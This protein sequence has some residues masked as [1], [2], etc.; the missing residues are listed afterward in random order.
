[1]PIKLPRP[2]VPEPKGP[3]DLEAVHEFVVV[4]K[5]DVWNGLVEKTAQGLPPI[6]NVEDQELAGR[7]CTL[8][9]CNVLLVAVETLLTNDWRRVS[10]V[11]VAPVLDVW[12]H[13]TCHPPVLRMLVL[14]IE[15]G[16]PVPR[17]AVDPDQVLVQL[18]ALV[19]GLSAAP[20]RE[21]DPGIGD[22]LQELPVEEVEG[23][24]PHTGCAGVP[25]CL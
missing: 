8:H 16:T 1:M 21:D 6:L 19:P 7:Y 12:V 3:P 10:P 13:V 24:V 9:T 11:D 25:D 22:V 4:W 18:E 5:W 2:L 23:V 17:V 14:K 15:V 20:D